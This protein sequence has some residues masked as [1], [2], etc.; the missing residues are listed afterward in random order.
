MKRGCNFLATLVS[1]AVTIAACGFSTQVLAGDYSDAVLADNPLAYYRL[2]ETAGTT[3]TNIGS[4]VGINGT[5][6]NENIGL[7]GYTLGQDGPQSPEFPG[8]E[9]TNR[10]PNLVPVLGSGGS[11]TFPRVE[12][13]DTQPPWTQLAEN[14]AYHTIFGIM[15]VL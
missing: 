8:L 1:L 12:V 4:G 7:G 9:A 6:V 13:V 3:A 14:I 2:D 15:S 5:Y 11:D 10:S